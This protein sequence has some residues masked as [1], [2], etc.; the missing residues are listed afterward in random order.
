[1]SNLMELL[2]DIEVEWKPL[3]EVGQ[4]IRGNGLQ[5]KDFTETGVPAIRANLSPY[6]LD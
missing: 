3:G 6:P 2:K 1:M 5:K 4:L